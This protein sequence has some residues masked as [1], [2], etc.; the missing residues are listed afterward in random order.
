MTMPSRY[1]ELILNSNDGAMVMT[2]DP[3]KCLLL[4]PVEE[5][6]E[7]EKSIAALPS[8]DKQA[9]FLKRLL[10]G[11]AYELSMDKNGRLL[12]PPPLRDFAG[13]D[14]QVM[15]IGQGQKFE[16]WNDDH[17]QSATEEG[18]EAYKEKNELIGDLGSLTF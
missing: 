4:Y 6:L 2:A 3:D 16:I 14:K 1:R 9:R 12:V 11:H 8:L 10:I 15:L 5:W 18:V 17:W 7:V 13:I